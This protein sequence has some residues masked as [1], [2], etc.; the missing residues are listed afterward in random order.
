[1]GHYE[2]VPCVCNYYTKGYWIELNL[3]PGGVNV[4]IVCAGCG[5]GEWL[6]KCTIEQLEKAEREQLEIMS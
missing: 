3:F 4:I 5:C 1:M 2:P 6:Q